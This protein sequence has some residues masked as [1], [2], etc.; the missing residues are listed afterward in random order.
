MSR[1]TQY[2]HVIQKRP[3]C[4]LLTDILKSTPAHEVFPFNTSFVWQIYFFPSHVPP[5]PSNS[6][7]LTSK[8]HGFHAV[9]RLTF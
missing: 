5:R 8:S 3:G 9:Q 2:V 4:S 1:V 7:G 6:H